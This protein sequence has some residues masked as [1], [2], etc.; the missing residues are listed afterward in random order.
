VLR[1]IK[2]AV[3]IL[4]SP[5]SSID[6]GF[7][8]HGD[9]FRPANQVFLSQPGTCAQRKT[10]SYSTPCPCVRPSYSRR[11]ITER[12]IDAFC[13]LRTGSASRQ[14]TRQRLSNGD[15]PQAFR[16]LELSSKNSDYSRNIYYRAYLWWIYIERLKPFLKWSTILIAL[17]FTVRGLSIWITWY[18]NQ[19]LYYIL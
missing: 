7:S 16:W 1:V 4:P 19:S 13:G 3:R 6:A 15:M 12:H 17:G 18:M 10:S 2:Q 14:S 8:I 9:W 5:A 11:A